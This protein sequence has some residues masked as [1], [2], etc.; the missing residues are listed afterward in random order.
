MCV[1]SHVCKPHDIVFELVPSFCHL[2]C[3]DQSEVLK[4]GDRYFHQLS[5]LTSLSLTLRVVLRC[6]SVTCSYKMVRWWHFFHVP[7]QVL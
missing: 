3:R 4:L 5:D 6:A 2:C 7:C 1:P